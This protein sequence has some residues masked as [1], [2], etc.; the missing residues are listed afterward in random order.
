M[1]DSGHSSQSWSAL[2]WQM[3]SSSPPQRQ[4]FTQKRESRWVGCVVREEC[5]LV[6]LKGGSMDVEVHHQQQGDKIQIQ[7]NIR[8]TD[9]WRNRYS[10]KLLCEGSQSADQARS[11]SQ[12]WKLVQDEHT[13]ILKCESRIKGYRLMHLPKGRFTD[14]FIIQFQYPTT[15]SY[16]CHGTWDIKM[17]CLVM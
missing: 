17:P 11:Q 2:K 12:G 9:N 8:T 3:K 4:T 10:A 7:E 16:T 1:K 5:M 6:G 13:G 15:F 14:K